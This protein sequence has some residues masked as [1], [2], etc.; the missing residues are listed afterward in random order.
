MRFFIFNYLPSHL[1]KLLEIW[2]IPI[3]LLVISLS[4]S[5]SLVS[6]SIQKLKSIKT[7]R[8]IKQLFLNSRNYCMHFLISIFFFFFDDNLKCQL[9][10]VRSKKKFVQAIKLHIHEIFK[11]NNQIIENKSHYLFVQGMPNQTTIKAY[12]KIIFKKTAKMNT[13]QKLKCIEI[14]SLRFNLLTIIQ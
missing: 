13:K 3:G 7:V 14:N 9:K 5:L 11:M 12:D 2:E 4:L 1:I 6:R 10:F 8:S